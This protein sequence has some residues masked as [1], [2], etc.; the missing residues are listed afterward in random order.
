MYLK[1]VAVEN[2]GESRVNTLD[3]HGRENEI[4]QWSLI[5]GLDPSCAVH[6][7]TVLSLCLGG[8]PK[9]VSKVADELLAQRFRKDKPLRFHVRLLTDLDKNNHGTGT[10]GTIDI[11]GEVS[12]ESGLGY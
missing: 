1:S 6:I 5:E 11:Y 12:G 8:K 2:L 10:I 9:N 4:K 3:F 7:F